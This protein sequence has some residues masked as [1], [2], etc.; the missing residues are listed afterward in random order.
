MNPVTTHE[1]WIRTSEGPLFGVCSGLGRTFNIDPLIIRIVFVVGLL[2]GLLSGILY[3]FLG[4]ALP[5]EEELPMARQPKLLGVCSRLS[6]NLDL[7]I[8]LV[9]FLALILALFSIGVVV[10][11]YIVLHFVLDKNI[12]SEDL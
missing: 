11:I 10:L 6:Q 5:K 9:R 4:I 8:G 7:D 3:L 12:S 2:A 1:R